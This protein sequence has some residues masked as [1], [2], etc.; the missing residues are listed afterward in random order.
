MMI[1][2]TSWGLYDS[3]CWMWSLHR[4]SCVQ[5]TAD[6]P[7][8]A[9]RANKTGRALTRG[10]KHSDADTESQDR[11]PDGSG[12]V[13][14]T[15]EGSQT[16]T[17]LWLHALAI[18]AAAIAAAEVP[19]QSPPASQLWGATPESPYWSRVWAETHF[20]W[21]Q[22]TWRKEQKGLRQV[23]VKWWEKWWGEGSGWGNVV[24]G[25]EGGGVEK[26]GTRRRG[27]NKKR[28]KNKIKL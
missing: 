27:V 16:H 12:S 26:G 2:H 23:V 25:V 15:W 9:V 4:P 13:K 14:S 8:E 28:N 1:I 3:C 21:A 10:V 22:V 11:A 7:N 6:E 17:K 20:L 24:G 19:E 5:P 18:R